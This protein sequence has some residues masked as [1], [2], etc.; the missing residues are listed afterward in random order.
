MTSPDRNPTAKKLPGLRALPPTDP[1]D[2]G[3]STADAAASIPDA[4]CA[5]P[6]RDRPRGR[7][8]RAP[9]AIAEPPAQ[10]A[11][12]A[13]AARVAQAAVATQQ[14]E[15]RKRELPA[16]PPAAP[17]ARRTPAWEATELRR[18]LCGGDPVLPG[19]RGGA[20]FFP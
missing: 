13:L 19:D 12:C 6:I 8:R 5:T 10:R 18:R 7:A 2:A 3:G 1:H 14:H 9:T 4:P 20:S 11:R 17:M 16:R 15:E